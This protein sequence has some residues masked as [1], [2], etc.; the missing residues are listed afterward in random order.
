MTGS[1]GFRKP[2]DPAAGFPFIVSSNLENVD[3]VT[4]KLIRSHVMRGKKKK[5]VRP[6]KGQPTIGRRAR[7]MAVCTQTARVKL[8]EVGSLYTSLIPSR[9]GSDLSFAEFAADIEL[10]MLLNIAKVTPFA[11]KVIF[12]LKVAIGL[13]EENNEGHYP[14]ARD[15]VGLHITA[16]AVESFIDRVLRHRESIINLA[17]LLHFQKGLTLLKER[18]LGEDEE[19]KIS[20]STISVVLKL[21]EA[22]HFDGDYQTSK[23]HMQGLR[24]M[25]DLR[26][27]IYVFRG[28]AL[29][30]GMLRCDL[31]IAMH[32]GSSHVFF[33]QPSQPVPD[34]PHNLL[35]VWDDKMCSQEYIEI[36]ESLDSSLATA[37]R[38]MRRFC[39]LVNIGTQTQRL[40]RPQ[41]IHETMTAV[42]YRLL[43]MDFTAGSI[44]EAIRHGLL[45]F[46]YHVFLQWQDIKLPYHCFP[47]IYKNCILG[48]ELVDGISSQLMIWLLMTGA[49]SLFSTSEEVWIRDGLRK[50]AD[51]CWVSSWKEMQDILK[52]F[53]WITLL[54]EQP[55]KLVYDTT[56][57]EKA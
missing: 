12:P 36:S 45:A 21:A 52:S 14:I 22:A 16:F 50:Q 28:K 32:N 13:Q 40:I 11:R 20:D 33:S 51:K 10:P 43:R 37:W 27:G 53:M 19:L 18:L 47:T 25:V 26:G 17:A 46:S 3:A 8:E 2:S 34:Y 57:L 35:R 5:K 23:Q 7:T 48:L 44:S 9:V 31:S 56:Y 54:D 38:I 55:G 30:V 4:R 29:E 39:V 6:D 24:K 49:L 41:T 1:D 15:V 42:M